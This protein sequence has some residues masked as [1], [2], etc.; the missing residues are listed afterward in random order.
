MPNTCKVVNIFKKFEIDRGLIHVYS[1][2]ENSMIFE[3]LR[4]DLSFSLSLNQGKDYTIK[5]NNYRDFSLSR[6]QIMDDTLMGFS[7]Y[8]LL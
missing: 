1:E 4:F 3:L 5:S 8:L 7:Q 6:E 2:R